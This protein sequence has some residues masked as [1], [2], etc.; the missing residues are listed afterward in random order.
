MR[1]H[2]LAKELGADSKQLLAIAAELGLGIKSHSTNIPQGAEGIL[3]AAWAEELSDEEDAGEDESPAGVTIQIGGPTTS[4]TISTPTDVNEEEADVT[5]DETVEDET[6]QESEPEDVE[7]EAPSESVAGEAEAAEAG[8]GEVAEEHDVEVSEEPES[9]EDEAEEQKTI[10][11]T[12]GGQTAGGD[13]DGEEVED[14]TDDT[15]NPEGG[16]PDEPKS[17]P[18]RRAKIVGRIDLTPESSGQSDRDDSSQFDP[19]DPT[20]PATVRETKP[21]SEGNLEDT[22]THKMKRAARQGKGEWVFDPEDT[23][24]MS[25]IRLGNFG[26]GR[27]S[28]VRRPSPRRNIVSSRRKRR[29]PLER[30]THA[31]TLRPP[32]GARELADALGI[33]SREILSYFPD[34]FDPRDKNAILQE[35]HLIQLADHLDREINLLEPQTEGERFLE[36]EEKRAESLRGEMEPRAPIV[37]VL[38]HVDHGKTTLL[39]ALRQANVAD[40]EVGGITQK[41]SA[42]LVRAESGAPVCFLDTPGHKAFTE[43]R[44]RG[45]E[46]TDVVVLVVAADDGVMEQTQEAIDHANAAE[47]PLLVVINKIDKANSQPDK[48]RQE[49]AQAGVMVEGWGGE[50]GCVE[51]SATTGDGL[52]ELLER[53]ALETEILELNADPGI[54]ARGVVIDSRKD[55]DIGIVTTVVVQEGTLRPKDAVLAGQSVGRVRYMHDDLGQRVEEAL[56]GTPVQVFGMEDPPAAGS[57]FLVVSDMNCA[58]V[59]VQERKAAQTSDVVAAP[60]VVT[61]ENLFEH[62]EAQ[63][64]SE[65]N[66]VIK[67]DVSG[68]LEVLQRTLEEMAHPEVRFRVIR[69]GVGAVSEEDVL[70]AQT[71]GAFVIAFGVRPDVNARAALEQTGVEMKYYDV[72]YNMVEELEQALEGELGYDD[73]ETVTGHATIREIFQSSKFGTI[74]GCYVTDG[75]I[76]RDNHVRVVRD[77]EAIFTGLLDSLRRFTDDVKEVRENYECGI[78]VKNYDDVKAED[79]L[80]AYSVTQVKRTLDGTRDSA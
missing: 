33:K 17:K 32:I 57:S 58:R 77:G 69:A 13:E 12:F 60:D 52:P 36:D 51:C 6:T 49:L 29:Q 34:D 19:L 71:S 44:A 4:L 8:P 78:H 72:I 55:P 38:G 22:I 76:S 2:E 66:V 39:D 23:T 7:S 68:S 45:T 1:L 47:V 46:A 11:V 26:R 80:E 61:L 14:E 24:A 16:S 20:R 9:P 10:S 18:R 75:T 27:R 48:V 37:T 42:Y 62:I 67:A 3:R 28:P 30:P 64:V 65:V 74:A 63:E 79:V 15:V 53:L 43:M 25:A 40:S 73:V 41:T 5:E 59:V 31:I 54:P 35:E 70:L 56:P 21:S 50:V